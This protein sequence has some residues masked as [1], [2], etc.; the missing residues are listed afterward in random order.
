MS[1]SSFKINYVQ[2]SQL[3]KYLF[4]RVKRDMRTPFV[5]KHMS[6]KYVSV[7]PFFFFWKRDSKINNAL[8]NKKFGVYNGFL[9]HIVNTNSHFKGYR[10]GEFSTCR[11]KPKHKFKKKRQLKRVIKKILKK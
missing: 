1:R 7:P 10:L 11:R 3:K 6:H 4:N 9:F 2:R 5:Y 8:L